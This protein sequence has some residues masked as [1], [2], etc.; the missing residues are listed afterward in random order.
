[1]NI[2]SI[3][4]YNNTRSV[5]NVHAVITTSFVTNSRNLLVTYTHKKLWVWKLYLQ[6]WNICVFSAVRTNWCFPFI[7]PHQ[8]N[9]EINASLTRQC[10]NFSS[11]PLIVTAVSN[12]KDKQLPLSPEGKLSDDVTST[13]VW[14]AL[15]RPDQSIVWL[16]IW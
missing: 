2:S 10:C 11:G 9:R 13:E 15:T 8:L 6:P 1:M 5:T 16:E 7:V 3:W 12:F 14:S 4:L